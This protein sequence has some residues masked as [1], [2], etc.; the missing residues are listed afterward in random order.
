M[1]NNLYLLYIYFA[2][3]GLAMANVLPIVISLSGRQKKMSTVAAISSVSSCGYGAL[4]IGPALIGF[5]AERSSLNHAILSLGILG[6][7]V[8]LT[9][10]KALK[11]FTENI[12]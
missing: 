2:L 3:L 9:A 1:T 6:V 7:L 11:S 12:A 8:C 4:I 10:A 5:I